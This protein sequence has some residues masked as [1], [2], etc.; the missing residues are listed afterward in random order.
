M[1]ASEHGAVVSSE[2]KSCASG[3]LAAESSQFK[4][5]MTGCRYV[6]VSADRFA[7]IRSM[8][9]GRRWSDHL[10][11]LVIDD[12]ALADAI[13]DRLVQSNVKPNLKGESMR[14][15]KNR[16]VG[17]RRR[18]ACCR[19]GQQAGD[20]ERQGGEADQSPW[21]RW[22]GGWRFAPSLIA[23][24]M[25]STRC[26]SASSARVIGNISPPAGGWYD[27]SAHA[28]PGP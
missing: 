6:S 15:V 12:P 28:C 17:C 22:A 18:A 20:G 4:S 27:G 7:D 19:N 9:A 2:S 10:D 3:R 8:H 5:L 23:S 14:R 21:R 11:A 24:A 13:L 1:H 26:A 25:L 16:A